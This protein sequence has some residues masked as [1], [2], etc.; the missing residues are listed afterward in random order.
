MQRPPAALDEDPG[1]DTAQI[2]HPIFSVEASIPPPP[3]AREVL[4]ARG[5]SHG[6]PSGVQL[7]AN[8]HLFDERNRNRNGVLQQYAGPRRR[9]HLYKTPDFPLVQG[10]N[11]VVRVVAN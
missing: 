9:D 5:P 7:Y 2:E 10:R 11:R 8:R 6:S 3:L 4:G 1:D